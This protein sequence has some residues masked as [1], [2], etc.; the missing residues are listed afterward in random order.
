MTLTGPTAYPRR[1]YRMWHLGGHLSPSSRG[2]RRALDDNQ[3]Q[4]HDCCDCDCTFVSSSLFTFDSC[5]LGTA[6][7]HA[8][9]LIRQ[10]VPR[11]TFF[12]PH[13]QSHSRTHSFLVHSHTAPV[14]RPP[15]HLEQLALRLTEYQNHVH[16]TSQRHV[17]SCALEQ[18]CVRLGRRHTYP[19]L[20]QLYPRVSLDRVCDVE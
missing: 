7:L 1:R 6:F 3:Q 10:N 12:L 4:H 20:G 19:A 17:H 9:S 11:Q 14:D 13:S 2:P 15:D 16:L 18:Q 5:Q 8:V